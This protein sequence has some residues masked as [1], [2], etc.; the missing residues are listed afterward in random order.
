MHDV[1][2][3]LVARRA[4]K[5]KFYFSQG[6]HRHTKLIT[7]YCKKS[8]K[9]FKSVLKLNKVKQKINHGETNIGLF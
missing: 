8:K 2:K 7:I 9:H 6:L 5:F 4:I 3:Y 1:R